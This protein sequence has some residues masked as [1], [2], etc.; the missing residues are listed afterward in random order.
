MTKGV[1]ND[2]V[3]RRFGTLVVL[4]RATEKESPRGLGTKTRWLVRCDCGVERLAIGMRLKEGRIKACDMNGHT[5]AS[6]V[7]K[8]H[9]PKVSVKS[10]AYQS[11]SHLKQRCL[12]P[13]NHK[14]AY[15]GGR[16]ITVCE[17]WKDSFEAFFED[18]G[19]RPST[20]H[21]I[22][23]KDV[24][25]NY[26]PGN[27]VW[28]TAEQQRLNTQRTVYVEFEGQRVRLHDYA[29]SLGLNPGNIYMRLRSGWTLEQAV[30][31][32]IRHKKKKSAADISCQ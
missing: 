8:G 28:A 23:R 25:G 24:N 17:R 2:L 13:K 11:W 16:G 29:K 6:E 26:E 15:Y 22:E 1:F 19:D 5:W 27:C 4:R 9:T 18:M 14:Y 3:G 12:N 20:A 7:W 30:T 32:P 10:P 21:S 31:I